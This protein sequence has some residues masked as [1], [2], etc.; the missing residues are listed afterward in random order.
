M[1]DAEQ[2]REANDHYFGNTTPVNYGD[3]GSGETPK[4]PEPDADE[5]GRFAI[6]ISYP[7]GLKRDEGTWSTK[8]FAE[9]QARRARENLEFIGSDATVEVINLEED[10]S[11]A[12]G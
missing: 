10:E 4:D 9:Y 8:R 3:L 7:D 11:D 6:R 1:S 12:A 2:A 5:A